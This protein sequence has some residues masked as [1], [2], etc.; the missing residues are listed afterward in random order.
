MEDPQLE[1]KNVPPVEVKQQHPSEE[2]EDDE[3]G[4]EVLEQDVKALAEIDHEIEKLKREENDEQ[5]QAQS[6]SECQSDSDAKEGGGEAVCKRQI[7]EELFQLKSEFCHWTEIREA[8]IRHLRE[9]A[10]YID[11][12]SR[13]S[14]TYYDYRVLLKG[15]LWHLRNLGPVF[16]PLSLNLCDCQ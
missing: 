13:R 6:Q 4:F 16:L 9:I 5:K 1:G 8:T 14:V 11:T 2:E 7:V 3:D 15:G 12:V 10:D